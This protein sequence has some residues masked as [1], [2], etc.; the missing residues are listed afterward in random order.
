MSK[1][2]LAAF[3]ILALV[4]AVACGDDDSNGGGNNANNTNNAN[5]TGTDDTGDAGTDDS[6][7]DDAG[8]ADPDGG[9]QP[10]SE[11]C[12]TMIVPVDD[13]ETNRQNITAA[14]IEPDDGDVICLGDGTYSLNAQLTLNASVS[15][16]EIRGESQ[17]GTVLDFD[18]QEDGSNGL[19]VDGIDGFRA[20]NFTVKNTLGD[21]IKVQNG[22]GV[23]LVNLTVTWDG[24]PRTSN[25]AYGVYPVLDT[26]VLVEGCEVS[27]ASDAG[28][29]VGQTDTAIVRNNE[30]F[31]N[32]AGLEIENTSNAEVHDNHLYENTGGLL[33]FNLPDLEVKDG[34]QN[35]IHSNT[36][37]DNN[38]ANFAESG[39]IVSNVPAG[40]GLFLLSTD[41]NEVHD[42]T[43][44]DNDSIGI[45]IIS[46][47]VLGED[48][49][50]ADYDPYSEGNFIH[51]NT[52]ENNG[53]AP[54][55][56]AAVING[57]ERVPDL[58]IDGFF[59][60][61]PPADSSFE[62]RRDCFDANEKADGSDATFINFDAQ[63]GF[64]PTD[65]T[66]CSTDFTDFCHY[67]CTRDPLPSVT[68]E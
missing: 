29:Y 46:Y 47:L 31:G 52:F 18:E 39:T 9:T 26:N 38:E 43:I 55:G 36:I 67:Q 48:I 7:T 34:S 17:D 8:D 14:L 10:F 62:D 60:P 59:N 58:A 56:L 61:D 50:D 63:D 57:G 20:A 16:V 32:V 19:L 25:G 49:E 33:V 28:I 42:N 22:D 27:Y 64:D 6:G 66:D 2:L 65:I 11:D 44:R 51:D 3:L 54:A 4:G 24:G 5:D 53:T 1:K 68:L 30:A 37:E 13:A 40:V 23:E 35:K 15:D 21:A 45:A 12:T 41:H